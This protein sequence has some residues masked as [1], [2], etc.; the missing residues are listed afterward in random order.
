[1]DIN[2]ILKAMRENEADEES[3]KQIQD[4]HRMAK[5]GTLGDYI[6]G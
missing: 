5:D 6:V 2:A 4:M 3:I 1:M